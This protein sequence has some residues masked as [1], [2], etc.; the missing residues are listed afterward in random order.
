MA[1]GLE[2]NEENLT[3][4]SLLSRAKGH[5]AV[6]EHD[7]AKRLLD[8]LVRLYPETPA[9]KEAASLLDGCIR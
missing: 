8:A 6:H 4:Q 3:A 1:H 5:L 9:A 7:S 2:D